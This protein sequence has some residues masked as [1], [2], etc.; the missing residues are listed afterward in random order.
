MNRTL[1]R[2]LA[3]AGAR[4]RSSPRPA[5]ATTT[6]TAATRPAAPATTGAPTRHDG[7]RRPSRRTDAG[8][9]RAPAAAPST[10][11]RART[12]SSSRPTGSPRPSTAR[13]T[14]WSARA[15][16]STPTSRSSRGPLVA[17]GEETGIDIEVRTGGP[18][19]GD[20]P[21]SVQ[22]YADDSITLGYANTEGQIAALRRDAG[23][24]G[25]RPARDQ[26]ADHLLGPRDVPGRRDARRPRRGGRDDQRLRRRHVRRRVRRR[27]H[28]ER[29]PGRPVLRRQPGPLHRRGRR[30]RPAGLRLG[31]A[32]HLRERVRGVGQAGRLP[33]APRRRLRGLL[34]DAVGR[35]PTSSRRC[36][37]A[38]R[39]S[40]PSSSRRPI[41]FIDAPTGPTRSS[42]TPSTQY[43]TS[44]STT[45]AS[46][47]SR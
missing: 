44:G 18:A 9:P 47:S 27:G 5:V 14:R 32:V 20:Q 36:G 2:S 11:R 4:R 41:D 7:R 15:T 6:T 8:E 34:A 22:Q 28:L 30:D 19:I 33:D 10:C 23:A 16:P 38:W 1:T 42:S 29:G 40:C 43:D 12:R 24:L 39:R 45:R 37:R 3:V 21:V 31:R 26:P 25:R 46:P 17:G 35:G 13:S